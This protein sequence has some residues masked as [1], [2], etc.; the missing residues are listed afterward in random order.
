MP[1]S[2]IS[3]IFRRI[4]FEER[5]SGAHRDLFRTSAVVELARS[6]E[7][8]LA[9]LESSLRWAPIL[10][11]ASPGIVRV[12]SLPRSD[13]IER[14]LAEA[15][16][17]DE[18][19]CVLASDQLGVPR[20]LRPEVGLRFSIS[21]AG[22]FTGRSARTLDRCGCRRRAAGPDLSRWRLG[23]QVLSA[24]EDVALSTP[25]ISTSVRRRFLIAR[26]VAKE[27]VLKAAGV[28]LA[29]DPRSITIGDDGGVLAL[30]ASL[31]PAAEWSVTWIA[32]DRYVGAVACR[33]RLL[34]V[35]VDE[36][37]T[38][39]GLRPAPRNGAARRERRPGSSPGSR[40]AHGP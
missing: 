8:A 19:G 28:G 39:A 17:V 40:E 11:F 32:L 21:R 26:W 13:G 33:G 7:H 15:C 31:G 35:R 14:L 1:D 24:A 36:R 25:P 4:V 2:Y 30:P 27:A 23:S 22:D 16:G 9:A 12:V 5:L 34:E 20:I 3:G 38:R 37:L 6:T 10:S 29:V 18:S